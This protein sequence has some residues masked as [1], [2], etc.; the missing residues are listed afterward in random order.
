M[1]FRSLFES[2]TE[3]L[4]VR[5]RPTDFKKI[6]ERGEKKFHFKWLPDNNFVLS[7]NF[8]FG[9]NLIFDVNYPN[10]K[11]DIIFYGKFTEIGESKTEIKLWTRSKYFLAILLIVLPVL[12]IA[13]QIIMK[14]EFP[15]F[16]I[17]LIFFP[18][19]IMVFLNLIKGEENRLL[20]IFKEYLNN[21]IITHY[22]NI[23]N[24]A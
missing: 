2:R 19:T 8:S 11:S 3:N 12:I 4:G 9:S 15:I 7:L 20:E 1:K 16:L 18:L 13:F 10:T 6:M 22:S 21:E 5:I 24:N 23:E 14:L 17:A